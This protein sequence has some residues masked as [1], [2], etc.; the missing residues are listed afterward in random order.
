MHDTE[1]YPL[2]S[3]GS[4][5]EYPPAIEDL[6]EQGVYKLVYSSDFLDKH[7]LYYDDDLLTIAVKDQKKPLTLSI[8]FSAGKS[9][10]RLKYGGGKNQPLAKACGLSNHPSW[11]IL[12][13]TAG[14]GKDAFVLA[15]LGAQVQL[16]EQHPILF[17]LLADA[18]HR[19]LNNL[20]IA[21]I[22]ERI[23]CLHKNSMTY[24]ENLR[25]THKHP[26]VIYLDPMYPERRKSA[27]IKKEMQILQ[28]L[29]GHSD[30]EGKLLEVACKRAQH[31]VVVKRPKSAENLNGKVPS[32]SVSS[33]N[34]RYDVYVIN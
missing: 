1:Q 26:D 23:Q 17:G 16:C 8:D 5:D 6:I 33:V 13:A 14:L 19:A 34:T 15:S 24:L 4:A 12:D 18:H 3:S 31:R 2:V 9:L 11:L 21:I 7:W 29:V 32:Y 30:D 27:K 25:A 22:A 20:D 10:H 28:E